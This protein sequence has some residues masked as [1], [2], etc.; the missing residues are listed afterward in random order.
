MAFNSNT[1]AVLVKAPAIKDESTDLNNDALTYS[2][3][4]PCASVTL[5][6]SWAFWAKLLLNTTEKSKLKHNNFGFKYFTV[7]AISHKSGA[8]INCIPDKCPL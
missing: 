4:L 5:P 2:I 6:V 7:I 1:P 3:G 8:K